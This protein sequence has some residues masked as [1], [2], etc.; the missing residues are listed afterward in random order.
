M[1]PTRT[2]S[3]LQVI[4]HLSPVPV[5]SIRALLIGG[6]SRSGKSTLAQDI[7]AALTQAGNSVAI[8]S[9][10]SWIVSLEDR[11]FN[12]RVIDRYDGTAA[13]TAIKRLVNGHAAEI[14]SYDV[15]KRVRIQ[16]GAINLKISLGSYLI[17]EGVLALAYPELLALKGALTIFVEATEQ[18]RHQ[19]VLEFYQIQKG[20]SLEAAETLFLEREREEVPYVQSTQKYATL[21]YKNAP[22]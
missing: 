11:P 16:D 1:T 10:D 19:R 15:K 21:S 14:P 4:S 22:E 18:I 13:V 5:D 6:C 17:I 2:S 9:L 12:S 7:K 20:L 3:V 8:V